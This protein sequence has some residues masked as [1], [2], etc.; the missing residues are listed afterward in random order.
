MRTRLL[1]AELNSLGRSNHACR[2]P[3]F[4]GCQMNASKITRTLVVLV[5]VSAGVARAQ[6]PTVVG[7]W[8]R[9]SLRDS[10]GKTAQPPDAP[11]FVIFSANGFFSQSAIPSGRPKLNKELA[12]LTKDE[13]LARFQHVD[14][15]RGTYAIAGTR[16]TRKTV[17]DVDPTGEGTEFVQL[18]RFA[19][20]TLILTRA[21]PADKSEARFV[22]VR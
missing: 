13:L 19:G 15:W 18:M 3:F 9:V 4:R 16:L 20:D 7:A 11:A 12:K 10:V 17:A 8:T 22:R 21:N 2:E 5:L 14:A 1:A 6:S